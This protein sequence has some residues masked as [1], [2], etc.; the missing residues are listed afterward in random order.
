MMVA[1]NKELKVSTT[2][3]SDAELHKLAETL[4]EEEAK[5]FDFVRIEYFAGKEDL[6]QQTYDANGTIC[7][8]NSK[9]GVLMFKD[10]YPMGP[11]AKQAEED[12][13]ND[14]GIV[15]LGSQE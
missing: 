14:D 2:A 7:I 5:G 10:Q 9:D 13:K 1:K 4:K 3:D 15:F 8:L 11:A 6:D 12:F